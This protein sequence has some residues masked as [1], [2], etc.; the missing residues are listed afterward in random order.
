MSYKLNHRVG[1][2]HYIPYG[3]YYRIYIYTEV[4]RSGTRALPVAEEPY[5]DNA[6][7]ARRRVY[8]LNG[9]SLKR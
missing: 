3:R 6:A 2:Y 9:W 5:Y 1:E 7:D 4:S 8:E